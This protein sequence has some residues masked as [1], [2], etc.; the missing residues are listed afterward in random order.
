VRFSQSK[1]QVP[2]RKVADSR[3]RTGFLSIDSV[4]PL[5]AISWLV[6]AALF[7]PG[8]DPRSTVSPDQ[9][10]ART[11]AFQK[12]LERDVSEV[13]GYASGLA[14]TPDGQW[15]I[16]LGFNE[17]TVTLYDADGLER[18]AGPVHEIPCPPP[19][20]CAG[21]DPIFLSQPHAVVVSPDGLLAVLT[22]RNG[23]TGLRLPSLELV[24]N[25][26]V[27]GL[28][29]ARHVVRDR[30]GENYYVSGEHTG[31]ARLDV[32]GEP[33]AFFEGASTPTAIS[34]SR[35]ERELLV[36][37]DNGRRFGILTIADLE[38][39]LSVDLPSDF[40]GQVI[41]PLRMDNRA[42]IVGGA[43]GVETSVT[44]P[45][46]TLSIDL[47]TGSVETVQ[48]LFEGVGLILLGDGNEW[49]EVGDASA[50][51]PTAV[52]TM[53]IDTNRGIAALHSPIQLQNDVSPCCDIASY[54][55]GNRVVITNAQ[56]NPGGVPGAR[57]IVYDVEEQ[58]IPA[59]N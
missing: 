9:P 35:D 4:Q 37:N 57:L 49:A 15:L 56:N 5:I 27:P 41:V 12:V 16:S 46:R 54:P 59:T 23:V 42:I 30:A 58:V 20:F 14:V 11:V 38:P 3:R 6:C 13:T 52:G 47:N 40:E 53:T 31:I 48:V 33:Q 43:S 26:Q 32:A 39:R 29:A 45:L 51:V 36:L 7:I 19:L 21:F 25:T 10:P 34:L 18:I 2:I 17:G 28:G 22:S 24:F 55:G 1:G 50:V 44:P 8:C